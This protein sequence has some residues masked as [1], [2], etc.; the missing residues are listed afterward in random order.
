MQGVH[1]TLYSVHSNQT[2]QLLLF[3][4]RLRLTDR[5]FSV[6]GLVRQKLPGHEYIRVPGA[7]LRYFNRV[8]PHTQDHAGQA[9]ERGPDNGTGTRWKN[10]C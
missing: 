8:L 3:R 10:R 4:C 6:S 2:L 5:G 9:H 7:Q 1:C